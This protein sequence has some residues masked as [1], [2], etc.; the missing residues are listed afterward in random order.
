MRVKKARDQGLPRKIDQLRFAAF[1]LFLNFRARAD[2]LNL[3]ILHGHR[4]HSWLLVVHGDNLTAKINCIRAVGRAGPAQ[5][6]A[7]AEK[8]EHCAYQHFNVSF[9]RI[10]FVFDLSAT[11]NCVAIGVYQINR[12][13]RQILVW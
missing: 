2:G 11:T 13:C 12:N 9:H 5:F 7:A 8:H 1:V 10:T 3:A 4:F 6:A